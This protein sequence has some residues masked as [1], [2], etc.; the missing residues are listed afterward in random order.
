MKYFLYTKDMIS[1][2]FYSNSGYNSLM[3][4][5]PYALDGWIEISED[6]YEQGMVAGENGKRPLYAY[7]ESGTKI[8]SCTEIS[9]EEAQD[10]LNKAEEKRLADLEAAGVKEEIL[11]DN[12][13][14]T[15]EVT[16]DAANIDTSAVIIDASFTDTS[17]AA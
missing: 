14:Q 4:E 1:T 17:S 9:N 10:I 12:S 2:C 16:I 11:T 5:N 15:E 7:D 6:L 3:E 8:A 13:N